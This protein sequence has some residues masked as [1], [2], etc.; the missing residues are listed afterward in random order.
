MLVAGVDQHLNKE[1]WTPASFQRDFGEEPAD[2]V[3][4]R[5]GRVISQIPTKAFW[6]GFEDMNGEQVEPAVVK[7]VIAD[8]A[9]VLFSTARLKDPEYNEA[10]LLKLKDWPTRE[11][12]CDKLPLRYVLHVCGLGCCLFRIVYVITVHVYLMS[13]IVLFSFLF[14]LQLANT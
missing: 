2:L 13:G 4:C 9:P 5:S 8:R 12:F 6:S 14:F 10:R 3:D 7:S 11:D 1:L